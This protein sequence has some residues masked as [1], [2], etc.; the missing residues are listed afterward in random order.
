MLDTGNY[1]ILRHSHK[2]LIDL[3]FI[4]M[5]ILHL[6]LIQ[7]GQLSVTDESMC[8]STGYLLRGQSLSKGSVSRLTD[9]YS[10]DWDIKLQTQT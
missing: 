1:C 6:L 5:V 2:F 3:E 8:T 9:L 10:F 7:E 4:S